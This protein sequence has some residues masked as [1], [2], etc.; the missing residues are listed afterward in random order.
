MASTNPRLT[1]TDGDVRRG[2]GDEGT[3]LRNQSNLML[4]GTKGVVG[5]T[6]VDP[7]VAEQRKANKT[8]GVWQG[9]AMESLKFHPG[10][11]YPTFVHSLWAGHS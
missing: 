7:A 4:D 6:C 8:M 3:P 11:P 1:L 5:D 9:V 2:V 10:P